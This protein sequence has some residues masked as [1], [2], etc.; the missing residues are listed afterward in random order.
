[1]NTIPSRP[2]LSRRSFVKLL[3]AAGVTTAGGYLLVEAAPWLDYEAQANDIRRPLA[4]KVPMSAQMRELIRYATLAANGHNTQPWQ[5]V[6]KDNAIEIHPDY[7]RRLPVVDP[8]DRELWISLGCALE[9]LRVAARA[10]GYAAEVTY[11]DGVDY[12]HIRLTAATPQNNPLFKA[13]ELRQNTRS[14]YDGHAVKGA[15]LDDVQALH[16]EPGVTLRYVLN[17]PEL[18][19]VLAYVHQGNLRQYADQ[20]FVAELIDWLR[21]NQKDALAS[22]DGLFSRC[23]GHPEVPGWLGRLFVAGTKPQQQADVDARKLRSSAGVVVIA[24]ESDDKATWVRTGQVYERLA[25]K[26]TSL[27]IK[28]AFLNQPLEVAELRSQFQSALS[29][30]ASWPQLLIRFGYAEAMPRS[31]R[32]PVEAVIMPPEME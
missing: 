31:L 25:L 20:A 9:N 16:L 5:F 6:L 27:N 24:S 1:M 21:F 15:D 18:E 7:T 11:P 14:D 23:S 22:L 13:I 29:L 12:I 17:S 2:R 3:A 8:H 28:S 10:T 4:R 30:G 26:M 19:T 32:R